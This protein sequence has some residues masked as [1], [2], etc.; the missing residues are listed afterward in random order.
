MAE[1]DLSTILAWVRR[2]GGDMLRRGTE[3]QV[4]DG[5][6][7]LVLDTEGHIEVISIEVDGTVKAGSTYTLDGNIIT[8]ASGES[9]AEG[10]EIF[11][12]YQQ[13]TYADNELLGFLVDAAKAIA[14]DLFLDWVV[15][16]DT[17]KIVDEGG[18]FVTDGQADATIEK[19]LVYKVAINVYDAKASRAA[20]DAIMI[21]DGSTTIDTS[22]AARSSEKQVEKLEK[23]YQFYLREAQVNRFQ[24]DSN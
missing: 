12:V 15:D 23:K 17:F 5:T 16:G 18:Q 1:Y 20:D 3:D 8:W 13:A 7:R 14:S 10:A 11:V 19:L 21:R 4:G 2:A 9:P 6:R 24:G 22:K